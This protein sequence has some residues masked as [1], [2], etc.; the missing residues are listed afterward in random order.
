MGD[1]IWRH[2]LL[3]FRICLHCFYF[4]NKLNPVAYL[5]NLAQRRF[6]ATR[7][8]RQSPQRT[9]GGIDIRIDSVRP[10]VCRP[11]SASVPHQIELHVATAAIKLKITPCLPRPS[12][13]VV[14]QSVNTPGVAVADR[15]HKVEAVVEIPAYSNRQK[16]A[17]DTALLVTMLEEK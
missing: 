8:R 3:L 5:N 14:R 4:I 12:L 1:A 11:N 10:P 17:A 6:R 9:S 16:Q 2:W 15:L 7:F 13:R